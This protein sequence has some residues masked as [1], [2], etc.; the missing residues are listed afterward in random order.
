MVYTKVK[1]AWQNDRGFYEVRNGF[2]SVPDEAPKILSEDELEK[3]M[4]LMGEDYRWIIV[5][6]PIYQEPN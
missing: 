2:C 4:E 5:E 1:S 6:N 3:L